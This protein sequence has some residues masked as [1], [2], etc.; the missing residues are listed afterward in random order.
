MNHLSPVEIQN[1]DVL[2]FSNNLILNSE[3]FGGGGGGQGH[4]GGGYGGHDT[5]DGDYSKRR[6][7]SDELSSDDEGF[8]LSERRKRSDEISERQ[9]FL[10]DV[11]GGYGNYDQVSDR[12]ISKFYYNATTLFWGIL[13]APPAN[14]RT[15]AFSVLKCRPKRGQL[16]L[17]HLSGLNLME[18]KLTI[19]Q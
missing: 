5:D 6:K 12:V 11:D 19:E 7:R 4:F 8:E 1:S 13:K 16:I 15:K 2:N 14:F 10:A 9:G 18:G 3:G 17:L